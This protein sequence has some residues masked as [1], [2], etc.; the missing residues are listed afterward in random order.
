MLNAESKTATHTH[1]IARPMGGVCLLGLM[2]L[3]IGLLA[4]DDIGQTGTASA[5]EGRPERQ[6]LVSLAR[7]EPSSRIINVSP[8][9]T[10]VAS[11]ILIE[12]GD[13]V[14]E[15]QV[16]LVL[17][18]YTLRLAELEAARMQVERAELEPLQILAQQAR[19][20]ASAAELDYARE[21]VSSQ[22]GLSAKGFS[23]GKEFRDAQLRVKTGEE[24]LAEAKAVLKQIEANAKLAV[25][26]A[27]NQVAQAEARFE[28]TQTRSPIDG[29]VL[30]VRA[31]EG[32]TVG[33]DN[34]ITL[35][36]TENMV[37]LGE[38]HVNEIRLVKPGQQAIFSSPA[39]PAPI[40]GRVE[41]VGAI[42]LGN[43]V[44]GEDPTAARGLRVVQVR[45]LLEPDVL[46]RR[47]TNLE[48]QLRI[49]LEDTPS[50]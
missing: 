5:S 39:L 28:Q 24:N 29:V 32:E 10:D 1:M 16:L 31:D 6:S 40:Q 27:H 43:Q 21:E 20:R 38:V 25:R 7:L 44:H 2:G 48:G 49:L 46:A 4:C 34:F 22:Q 42:V 37:A 19:V 23:A 13:P 3:A 18:D 47:M 9:Y 36:A 33:M 17:A 30:R 26:E 35:G 45:V 15:G 11:E 41:S 50:L 8:T 14:V 12:E